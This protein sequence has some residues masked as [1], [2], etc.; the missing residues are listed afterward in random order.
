MTLPAGNRCR[1]RVLRRAG[2]SLL[3][4]L[5]SIGILSVGLLSIASLIPAG[6]Y[7]LLETTKVDNAAMCGRA[8]RGEIQTRDLLNPVDSEDETLPRLLFYNPANADTFEPVVNCA[9]A[10]VASDSYFRADVSAPNTGF[11]DVP[12]LVASPFVI[13]PCSFA[14]AITSGDDQLLASLSSFPFDG[15]ATINTN[16]L[17]G[18]GAIEDKGLLRLAINPLDRDIDQTD[19]D[20]VW[21]KLDTNISPLPDTVRTLLEQI[22]VWSDDMMI[23][24]DRT[25]ADKRPE[26]V[27]LW[28]DGS[29]S[30]ATDPDLTGDR[31]IQRLTMGNYSWMMTVMPSMTQMPRLPTYQEMAPFQKTF[32]VSV[33]VFYKRDVVPPESGSGETPS[34]RLVNV[35]LYPGSDITLEISNTKSKEYL[36]VRPQAVALFDWNHKR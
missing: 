34:E 22:F 28:N 15:N 30:H 26:S 6:Q 2:I 36:N 12:L 19:T 10:W 13:D 17:F 4:V 9:P 5:I 31:P 18:A 27:F 11:P 23:N 25:N 1:V 21:Q 8:A 33:V 24:I 3:E 16:P 35:P 7:A 20:Y 32:E 14:S 29:A